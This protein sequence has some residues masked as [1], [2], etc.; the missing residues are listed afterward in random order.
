MHEEIGAA[1]G[2]VWRALAESGPMSNAKVKKATGL[3]PE[4]LAMA[5]GWLA[6]ENQV[7]WIREG[8]QAKIGVNPA[9]ACE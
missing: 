3:K 1:A 8:R 5:L 2:E 6:R 9:G 7:Q 4:L